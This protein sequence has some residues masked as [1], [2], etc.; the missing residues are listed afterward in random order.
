MRKE[1]EFFREQLSPDSRI[2]WETPIAHLIPRT[3]T[4]TVFG[5][6]SL[7]GAGGYS[8]GLGFWWHIVFPDDIVKRTLLYRKNNND[9]R[10]ISINVLE[11][12]TV[13]INYCASLHTIRTTSF[14]NDP[15]PV[16]LNMTD[17]TSA[18]SWTMHTCKQSKIG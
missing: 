6:S 17:N 13:I 10:L 11:Y 16:I 4:A 18:L 8:L 15:Y 2:R 7:D 9:G 14:T 5:D 3:P 1:I 12:L